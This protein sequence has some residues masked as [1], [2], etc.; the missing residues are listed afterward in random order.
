[1]EYECCKKTK[2]YF[3]LSK[4]NIFLPE[5]FA[6]ITDLLVPQTIATVRKV[7][8][9][10]GRY[11][12]KTLFNS[13]ATHEAM[14][15]RS[16]LPPGVTLRAMPAIRVQTTQGGLSATQYIIQSKIRFPEFAYRTIITLV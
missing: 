9:K 16:K 13:V 1:M 11:F 4:T 12:G 10:E 6:P 14:I 5:M 8:Q 2:E 3:V 15:K 7:N